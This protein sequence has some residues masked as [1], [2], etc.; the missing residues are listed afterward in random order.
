[1]SRLFL[2]SLDHTQTHTT[3]GRTPL[4]EGSARRRDLCLTRQTP[5]KTNTHAFGGIRTHDPIKRLAADLSLRPRGHWDRQQ[6]LIKIQNTGF[7][8]N[9]PARSGRFLCG[10]TDMR[11][12]K[13]S[14]NGYSLCERV[15]IHCVRKKWWCLWNCKNITGASLFWSWHSFKG[16][17][18]DFFV[19]IY[20]MSLSF[21][22]HFLSKPATIFRTPCI[23]NSGYT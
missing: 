3:V 22:K 21:S 12:L 19:L 23:T 9:P 8:E 1:V 13:V 11:G 6:S 16:L 4:D 10:Q 5:Y 17:L 18:L 15:T 2:F 7:S 20:W 14:N